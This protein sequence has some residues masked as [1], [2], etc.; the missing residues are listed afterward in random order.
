MPQLLNLP[1]QPTDDSGR[2]IQSTRQRL[3][4]AACWELC[5]TGKQPVE[6]VINSTAAAENMNITNSSDNVMH[7][8]HSN[9]HCFRVNGQ[10]YYSPNCGHIMIQPPE[11][12]F[13]YHAD[14]DLGM[15]ELRS[16]Q[17]WRR[18]HAWLGFM[19]TRRPTKQL[20]FL[21]QT[22]IEQVK[23]GFKINEKTLRNWGLIDHHFSTMA[24]PFVRRQH[25]QP[26]RQV[27]TPPPT[28]KSKYHLVHSTRKGAAYACRRAQDILAMWMAYF[29]YQLSAGSEY[30]EQNPCSSVPSTT[31]WWKECK[32]KGVPQHI[33]EL[34]YSNSLSDGTIP[35]AGIFRKVF[36][37]GDQPSIKWYVDRGIPVWYPWMV[38][39]ESQMTIPRFEQWGKR[40]R[41]PQCLLNNPLE[42]D[43]FISLPSHRGSQR[44]SLPTLKEPGNLG[45]YDERE[46]TRPDP[47]VFDIPENT[48]IVSTKTFLVDRSAST[49]FECLINSPWVKFFSDRRHRQAHRTYSPYELITHE[50]RRRLLPV[51][52]ST[53]VFH[54]EEDLFTN[55]R[56]RIAADKDE[57][58]NLLRHYEGHC[59][60]DEIE[61]EWDVC[62]LFEADLDHPISSFSGLVDDTSESGRFLESIT[63]ERKLFKTIEPSIISLLRQRYGFLG[64]SALASYVSGD[65]KIISR[66]QSKIVKIL[67]YCDEGAQAFGADAIGFVTGTI[68]TISDQGDRSR[69]MCSDPVS[70]LRPPDVFFDLSSNSASAVTVFQRSSIQVKPIYPSRALSFCCGRD[71]LRHGCSQ[72]P[73]QEADKR[74]W[75]KFIFPDDKT[76]SSW[77]LWISR[78]TDALHCIRKLDGY[79]E[80]E[81]ADFLIQHGIPF[82]TKTLIS[83]RSFPIAPL[84]IRQ[85]DYA[86]QIFCRSPGHVFDANDYRAYQSRCRD[87]LNKPHGRAALLQ[88]GILWRI[89]LDILSVDGALQGPSTDVLAYGRGSYLSVD[90]IGDPDT[91]S[92][93]GYWDDELDEEELNILSGLYLCET[94]E[95]T[96]FLGV[97]PHYWYQL[98]QKHRFCQQYNTSATVRTEKLVANTFSL[99]F[100]VLWG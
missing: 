42:I 48:S 59:R 52:T 29:A 25:A 40:Y 18:E 7:I 1:G 89:A 61:D 36:E 50:N 27:L 67:G 90:D 8:A 71:G 81:V 51:G 5:S 10:L 75:Y 11:L 2:P 24:E 97:V 72:K 44:T 96:F 14:S 6:H 57:N 99:E 80:L 65:P 82:S 86:Q 49:A 68:Q 31:W 39:E 26:L 9:G 28:R 93:E 83:H 73:H 35:R 21:S 85:P 16:P 98:N 60:Y 100:S 74:V 92:S 58:T 77:T 64:C 19:Q 12:S 76:H 95:S 66:D 53:R 30:G 43:R 84:T 22:N 47:Q 32:D 15:E 78:A 17:W 79:S 41:P 34:V 94:G 91:L 38:E 62:S 70:R 23:G 54:W 3:D 13:Q 69:P 63:P 45:E 4:T 20:A 37:F 56:R 88:G 46:I 33:L 55:T 87:L